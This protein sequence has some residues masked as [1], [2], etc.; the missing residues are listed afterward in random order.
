MQV[1]FLTPTKKPIGW[2]TDKAGNGIARPRRGLSRYPCAMS[3][4]KRQQRVTA[5]AAPAKPKKK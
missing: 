3:K 1:N 2:G 4:K 5:S